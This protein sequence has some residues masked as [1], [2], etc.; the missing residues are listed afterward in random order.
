MIDV[1]KSKNL[2]ENLEFILA[3][4]VVSDV[5]ICD[6]IISYYTIQFI[7]P[8]YRQS[9]LD[10]IYRSLNWGGAFFFFEKVRAPDARFQDIQSQYYIEFKAE[11]GFSDQEILNKQRSLFGV[12]EP[13]S[14]QGNLDLLKRAGFVDI[15][16][17]FRW[18]CFEGVL[19]I[20]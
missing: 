8:K 15:M 6:L 12:M 18:A 11:N 20:R 10:K 9:V 13:F 7:H 4:V 5:P 16:P 2:A 17:I 3:D 14:S 19:A 1:A